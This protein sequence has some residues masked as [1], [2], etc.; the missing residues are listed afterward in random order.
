MPSP[1]ATRSSPWQHVAFPC[2]SPPSRSVRWRRT[3]C[4]SRR[5]CRPTR[6]RTRGGASRPSTSP[7]PSWCS[8]RGG[9][10]CG[11]HGH[12]SS[13]GCVGVCRGAGVAGRRSVHATCCRWSWA[14]CSAASRTS[15]WD[16]FTHEHGFVVRAWP[17]LRDGAV[18]GYPLPFL[19]QDLS[20]VLG[21]LA[22]LV[23]AAVWW[24]RADVRPV[25]P[26]RPSSGSS[27]SQPWPWSSSWRWPSGCGRSSP[28]AGSVAW[29]PRWRS[30]CRHSSRSPWSW[31][32]SCCSSA[33]DSAGTGHA[34][35]RTRHRQGVARTSGCPRVPAG[36][37]ANVRCPRCRLPSGRDGGGGPAGPHACDRPV[38]PGEQVGVVAEHRLQLQPLE[39]RDE[40][41]GGVPR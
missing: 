23:V 27:R 5:S 19:L 20:S 40:L 32:P 7:S 21:L 28:A 4:C 6:T 13:R 15:L 9:S 18:G 31:V 35:P 1:S 33:V 2:R 3:R 26:L 16:G 37:C 25:G 11:R 41:L 24:R 8:P 14:A 10:S 17:A 30:G 22:L 38:P 29:S 12:R 34:G 39:E 36:R